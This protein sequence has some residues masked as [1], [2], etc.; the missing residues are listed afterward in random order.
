MTPL[1]EHDA[2]ARSLVL[3]AGVVGLGSEMVAI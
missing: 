3:G 2:V 1:I